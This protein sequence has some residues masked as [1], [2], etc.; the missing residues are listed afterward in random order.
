MKNFNRLVESAY[1]EMYNNPINEL[2]GMSKAEK[3]KAAA[4]TD[5][6]DLEAEIDTI[7]F[8][9]QK[10]WGSSWKASKVDAKW[11]KMKKEWSDKETEILKI[12]KKFKLNEGTAG[13]TDEHPQVVLAKTLNTKLERKNNNRLRLE[14]EYRTLL[15]DIKEIKSFDAPVD[16]LEEEADE[17]KVEIKNHK[18]SEDKIRKKLSAMYKENPGLQQAI[19]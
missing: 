13:Y 1:A 6:K 7:Q 15:N 12:K 17:Y 3:A 2:F 8:Q 19:V 5:I 10:N 9:M 16:D 14:D 18:K 4:E 11:V